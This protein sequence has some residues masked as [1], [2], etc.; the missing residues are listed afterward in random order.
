[1]GKTL[2]RFTGGRPLL[3]ELSASKLN[4]MVDAITRSVPKAGRNMTSR[5]EGDGIVLDCLVGGG[6]VGGGAGPGPWDVS[7]STV[8][9]EPT[10]FLA[11]VRPGTLNGILPSNWDE[12]FT[13]SGTSIYYA[14]A[15][16]T[17]DG[18]SV[19]GV[20]IE[21]ST[22]APAVQVPQSFGIETTVEY[23][24]GLIGSGGSYRTIGAGHI[25]LLPTVWLTKSADAPVAPG[26]LPWVQ[27]YF[28]S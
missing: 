23:L 13:M 19:S 1:M 2:S 21:I 22:D 11:K 28:L 24:F 25:E 18:E 14:K 7:V 5:Q 10:Q 4:D 20:T 9:D 27:L 16:I 3:S 8:Q 12:E 6:G 26:E 17:T 15:I